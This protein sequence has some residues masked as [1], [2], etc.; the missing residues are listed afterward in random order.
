L[1][2]PTGDALQKHADNIVQALA[3][4]RRLLIFDNLESVMATG[5]E[6]RRHGRGA[7]R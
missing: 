7:L 1:I 3:N 2:V 5:W 6:A 4:V